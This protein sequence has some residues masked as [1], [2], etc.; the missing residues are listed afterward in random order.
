MS[1]RVSRP[2]PWEVLKRSILCGGGLP[3]SG[4]YPNLAPV[5]IAGHSAGGQ[6]VQRYS[7]GSPGAPEGAAIPVRYVVMNPSSYMYFDTRRPDGKEGFAP[8]RGSMRCLVNAYK[9]GAEGR[10]DYM[11][12]EPLAAMVQRYRRRDVVYLLGG[13]D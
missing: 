2:A 4:F 8:A 3:E 10:N 5:V 12:A 7:L 9:Y 13:A 11:T 1:R 6:F